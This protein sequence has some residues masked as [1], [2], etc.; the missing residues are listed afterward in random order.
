MIRLILAVV[1]L[2]GAVGR[3]ASAEE[4]LA[5]WNLTSSTIIN[6]VLAPAGSGQFGPNQCANDSDGAVDHDERL[7]LSGVTPGRYDVKLTRK[8]GQVCTVQN[9]ELKAGGKYAFSLSDADLKDCR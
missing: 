3:V 2:C 1:V 5:F 6:L 9:V 7:R 8:S 4:R